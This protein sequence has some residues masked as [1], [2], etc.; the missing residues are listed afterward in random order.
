MKE[1][2]RERERE[3]VTAT[4]PKYCTSQW[5][6]RVEARRGAASAPS[7]RDKPQRALLEGGQELWTS[8]AL[9]DGCIVEIE[10]T[11]GLVYLVTIIALPPEH[12]Q[13]GGT[14][15]TEVGK[16]YFLEE[17]QGT[18]MI[19]PA[20]GPR[21]GP[22]RNRYQPPASR[23]G[24]AVGNSTNPGTPH[25]AATQ[26][27]P[28]GGTPNTGE[29]TAGLP[30][31]QPASSPQLPPPQAT[32]PQPQQPANQP[33]PQQPAARQAGDFRDGRPLRG[34]PQQAQAATPQ[35]PQ[36]PPHFYEIARGSRQLG[37]GT[38]EHDNTELWQRRLATTTTTTTT[39]STTDDHCSQARTGGSHDTIG[40]T[41]D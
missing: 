17:I 2:E 37:R 25:K 13:E 9:P 7:S 29:A 19:R 20:G 21:H 41:T 22:P 16:A 10:T 40:T 31:A 27:R 36:P 38:P 4:A 32:Q 30:Q 23:T 11:V 6:A 26:H 28:K 1:R 12:R 8:P 33:Q 24:R 39:T 34:Q 35:E 18:W 3:S 5:V 15:A 14:L